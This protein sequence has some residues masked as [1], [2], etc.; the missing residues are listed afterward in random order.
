LFALPLQALLGAGERVHRI[1]ADP[2]RRKRR[3]QLFALLE[4]LS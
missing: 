2:R 1:L 4:A 3:R